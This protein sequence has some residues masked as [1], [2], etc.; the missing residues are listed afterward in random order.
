MKKINQKNSKL[1]KINNKHSKASANIMRLK[2]QR[3]CKS[4]RTKIERLNSKQTYKCE[5]NTNKYDRAVNNHERHISERINKLKLH[6]DIVKQRLVKNKENIKP[7][8]D[9]E[10]ENNG[11]MPKKTTND[12]EE[13]NN[14][15][16]TNKTNNINI[17]NDDPKENEN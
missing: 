4:L 12:E 14:N 2:T 13:A 16:L 15:I 1:D 7:E 17:S 9:K 3:K 11:K 5:K 8:S 10:N 6:H